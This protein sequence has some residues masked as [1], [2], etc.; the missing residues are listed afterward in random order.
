[1]RLIVVSNRLPVTVLENEGEFQFTPSIGGLATGLKAYLQNRND[2]L[3]TES[4]WLGWPGIFP[5][6]DQEDR[7]RTELLTKFACHPVFYSPTLHRDFYLNFCNDGLWPLFH[8]LPTLVNFS[9]EQWTQY[10]VVNELFLL[11]LTKIIK[12]D[13]IVW[14]QD[15]HLLLLPELIR[16]TFPHTSIGFFLHIPFPPFEVFRMLAREC[17]ASLLSGMLGADLIGFHTHDYAQEFLKCVV[18]ICSVEPA[19]NKIF[20]DDRVVKIDSYPMGI[21]YESFHREANLAE[22]HNKRQGFRRRFN[23][24]KLI[25]SIDR[26][27]YTK[28]I[29]N[30]LLAY[31]KFLSGCP[32]WREKVTLILI[33]VPSRVEIAAY[34]QMKV[35][36]D[37]LVGGINGEFSNE[38]WSPIIYQYKSK[39]FEELV[40]LYSSVDVAL[41]TPLRDGMNLIAKE[42]VASRINSDGV[43][44]LSEMAGASQELLDAKTINP[45][46]VEEIALAIRECLCMPLEEQHKRMIKMQAQ[47]KGYNVVKWSE[48]I[49]GDVLTMRLETR[50]TQ[51]KIFGEIDKKI[52]LDEFLNTRDK[53]LLIDY[54]GTLVK[55]EKFPELAAPSPNVLEVITGFLGVRD[56]RVVI[57]SGRDRFTLE[58]WFGGMPVDLIA[59]NGIWI[60]TNGAWHLIDR[61]DDNWKELVIPILEQ[62]VVK[63]PGSFIE[64]KEFSLVWHF[65]NS[66]IELS[67]SRKNGLLDELSS[68]LDVY[69]LAVTTEVKSIEIRQKGFSKQRMVSAILK[70]GQYDFVSCFGDDYTDE[71]VFKVLPEFAYTFKVGIEQTA[72][73][74]ILRDSDDLLRLLCSM[75]YH[76]K[77]VAV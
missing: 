26:L 7:L 76:L 18:R 23:D 32:E 9:E 69:S 25:L 20:F 73:K 47:V 68:I 70:R 43:L 67:K 28:G 63:L 65:R 5:T 37:E 62:Y 49:L 16:K 12:D 11:E 64:E 36:I 14:V 74:F 22:V 13:D 60:K 31:K 58:K 55:F 33:L 45:F 52:F 44:I 46:H 35:Q 54:D 59:E 57:L 2:T 77:S 41:I 1:M 56:T 66:D 15:F 40:V 6:A 34:K 24:G 30:R 48:D 38:T 21:D 75:Q 4:L 17:S 51:D 53:L 3:I 10:R 50:Q 39:S 8:S 71:E 27:D 42:F 61:L 19:N 29:L 72:A